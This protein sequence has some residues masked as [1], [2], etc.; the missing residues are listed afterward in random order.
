ML[1]LLQEL[2]LR[3]LAPPRQVWKAPEVGVP[4]MRIRSTLMFLMFAVFDDRPSLLN[5]GLTRQNS[6]GYR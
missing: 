3:P 5:F 6:L 2:R 4:D 1:V